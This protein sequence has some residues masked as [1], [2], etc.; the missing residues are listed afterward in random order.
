MSE[1]Q[2][3]KAAAGSGKTYQLTRRFLSLVD[4]ASTEDVPRVCGERVREG[5]SWPEILAVTFTNKAAA[6]MKERVVEALKEGALGKGDRA[7]LDGHDPA[8]DEAALKDILR[9]YHRLN[10][11]TIDSLLALVL[12]LFALEKGLD[13][14]FDVVFDEDDLFEEVWSDFM[15]RCEADQPERDR[16]AAMLHAVLRIESKKGFLIQD[17]IRERVLKLVQFL[18]TAGKPDTDG[19]AMEEVLKK[20]NAKMKRAVAAMQKHVTDRDMAVNANFP[21]ALAKLDDIGLYDEL[22]NE[23]KFLSKDS[24]TECCNK[25]GIPLVDDEG[26]RVYAALKDE[27]NEW[28]RVQTLMKG[29]GSLAP[30]VEVAEDL[31]ERLAEVERR[32]GKV[33]GSGIAG[34]VARLLQD[35]A[36]P[37]AFCRLGSRLHHLL[38]D[39]F[40]D[41]SRDQWSAMTPLAEECLSKGGS[42]Y[43]VGDVKQA[44]YGWRGG[45][46]D[47]FDEVIDQAGLAEVASDRSASTL[48]DNWRSFEEVV[49]FNNDFFRRLERGRAANELAASV[50]I[51]A[52]LT[53]KADFAR[54]INSDFTDCAQGIAPRNAETGGYVRL[55]RLSGGDKSAVEEQTLEKLSGLMDELSGRRELKDIAILVRGKKHSDPVC[56]MLLERNIPFITESSLRLD[57]H[58]V[59]RELA[60]LLEYIDAPRDDTAFATFITGPWLFQPASGLTPEAVLEFMARYADGPLAA[61]FRKAFPEAWQTCIAPFL[62]QAGLMTPYDLTQ[63]AVEAFAVLERYPDAELYVRRFLEVVHLAEESGF[64]SL[65]EFLDYWRENSEEEKVPLPENVDAVR[66]MTMHKSKGLEFPVVI[67][68][69]HDWDASPK[70]YE[71][72]LVR[73]GG[74]SL[75]TTFRKGLGAPY[76]QQLAKNS[77]EQLNL[78]YVAWTRAAQE[79]YGFWV[80]TPPQKSSP[81]PALDAIRLAFDG[82]DIVEHGTRPDPG[83]AAEK[84]QPAPGHALPPRTEPPELGKWL[85]RMRVHRHT[86]DEFFYSERTRGDLAHKAFENLRPTGDDEADARRA[87]LLALR[88]FPAICGDTRDAA[89][90]D[91]TSML[92]WALRE[93]V[94][95]PLLETGDYEVEVLGEDG[96]YRRLDL[97]AVGPDEAVVLDFK[98]GQP[99]PKHDQQVRD[100][101]ALLRDMPDLP[102]GRRGLLAYL[103]LHE[104]RDVREA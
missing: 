31:L 86:R 5:Y 47:L 79:L 40:Q 2:Q 32:Q 61:R 33:V 57:R 77:R 39:E 73:E 104:V 36:V 85:P 26:E 75:V 68:P 7:R 83:P 51:D 41:T 49:R 4:G 50:L 93:P 91:V 97:L 80:D 101:L 103:D 87:V 59:V 76:W 74:M 1:L 90:T 95:R 46:A 12:R 81:H 27:W 23:S 89:E 96:E 8:R 16:F 72:T 38:V 58:P 78:L 62:N 65:T 19:A 99:D 53:I 82:Q 14:G 42:L 10:I 13:P 11:R 17:A 71:F 94:L 70:P 100:Y 63:E 44:I 52:D 24:L 20:A 30:A 21:K 56:D 84:P 66:V 60:A 98:T 48:P 55:E 28:K 54:Q 69:F 18:R 88:A 22:E 45:D 92:R 6:E 43:Y 34:Y 3:V 64:G 67:V 29:A 15:A 25:K 102:P 9:R 35:P 37:E